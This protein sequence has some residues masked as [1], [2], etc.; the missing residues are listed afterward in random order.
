MHQCYVAYGIVYSAFVR[1]CMVEQLLQGKE[2][3]RTVAAKMRKER[4]DS[5]LWR[6]MSFAGGGSLEI[7]M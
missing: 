6:T 3:T 4:I 7:L 2:E 5:P 1:L